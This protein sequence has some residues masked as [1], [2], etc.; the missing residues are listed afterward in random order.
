MNLRPTENVL[1]DPSTE[2]PGLLPR[3]SWD[4]EW[5]MNDPSLNTWG[6]FGFPPC[7]ENTENLT[8]RFCLCTFGWCLSCSWQN[9]KVPPYR[10][11]VNEQ[12]QCNCFERIHKV[13]SACGP[14]STLEGDPNMLVCSAGI[15]SQ[16]HSVVIIPAVLWNCLRQIT[17]WL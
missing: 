7:L 1:R 9:V 16:M 2:A 11:P 5:G 6:Q 13:A 3:A 15:V 17:L 8:R 4:G 10:Y 14:S 12:R